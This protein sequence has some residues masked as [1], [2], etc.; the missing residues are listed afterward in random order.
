MWN[1]TQQ[2]RENNWFQAIGNRYRHFTQIITADV[3]LRLICVQFEYA[4]VFRHGWR[5]KHPLLFILAV[6]AHIYAHVAPIQA[7]VQKAQPNKEEN[8]FTFI[9]MVA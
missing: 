6:H 7:D 4:S 3:T 8:T 2:A 5:W 1:I 9:E